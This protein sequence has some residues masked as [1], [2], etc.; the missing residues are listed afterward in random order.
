MKGLVPD[1]ILARKER[2]GFPVPLREWLVELAPWVDMNIAEMERLPF[3]EP[4]R[5]RQIWE[6]VQS[7]DKSITS[8]FLIWRWVFLAGWMR[9]FNVSYK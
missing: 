4:G 7:A 8:A 5:V 1:A 2:F 6:R 3:F 9:V